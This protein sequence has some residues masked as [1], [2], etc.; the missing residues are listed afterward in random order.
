MGRNYSDE[1]KKDS[2][3]KNKVVKS[4][5]RFR[6]AEPGAGFLPLLT[7]NS[8]VQLLVGSLTV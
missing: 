3:E 2:P 7:D 5:L 8:C 4:A 6:F 1:F